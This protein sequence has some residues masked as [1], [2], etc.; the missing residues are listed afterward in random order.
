MKATH[1]LKIQGQRLLA[2]LK[3]SKAQ[4]TLTVWRAADRCHHQTLNK[5]RYCSH[6]Q[7]EEQRTDVVSGLE[8]IKRHSSYIHTEEPMIGTI[9]RLET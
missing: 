5:A 7:P 9:S 2:C 3:C 1:C 4:Q 8:N 6:S